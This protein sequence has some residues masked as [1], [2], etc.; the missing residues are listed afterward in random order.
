MDQ[1]V[2]RETIS[3]VSTNISD[4]DK[5][6]GAEFNRLAWMAL[7]QAERYLRCGPEEARL[8]VT[9][10]FLKALTRLSA[11]DSSSQI[12]EHRT[13]FM[14]YITGEDPNDPTPAI[15]ATSQPAND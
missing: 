3:V 6:L 15:T 7:N 4:E 13:A 8:S 10:D 5:Q 12:E 1:T 11:A 14:T 2:V 9:K